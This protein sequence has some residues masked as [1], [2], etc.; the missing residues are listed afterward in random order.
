MSA[1]AMVSAP[2][3]CV[4]GKHLIAYWQIVVGGIRYLLIV[5][6]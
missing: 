1:L 3:V 5:L 6:P 4:H 2:T